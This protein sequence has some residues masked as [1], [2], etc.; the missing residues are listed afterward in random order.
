MMKA[1]YCMMASYN[2]WANQRLYD[3]AASLSDAEYR[4]DC[5]AFFKSLHGTL[6]H[7]LVTDGIWLRRFQQRHS[8]TP[9]QLDAILFDDL[10]ALRAARTGQDQQ[11]QD[12]VN[13][14]DEQQLAGTIRYRRASTP[15]MQEQNLSSALAHLF[16][17]QTHHRGQAHTILSL[18]QV[19]PPALDLLF[20][21][22][23]IAQQ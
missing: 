7:L 2:T 23:Q 5:G 11:L 12:Y 9:D 20:Y 13:A 4:R 21:Q 1:H 18:L 6:N 14:L 17:H 10:A 19:A 16:N 22:R 15:D 3:A 8:D